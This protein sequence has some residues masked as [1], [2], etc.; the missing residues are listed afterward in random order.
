MS[1]ID[2]LSPLGNRKLVELPR[3]LGRNISWFVCWGVHSL[4]GDVG[5]VFFFISFILGLILGSVANVIAYRVPRGESVILPGSHCTVCQQ[6][7]SPWELVPILS[8]LFLHGRCSKCEA[9]VSVRYPV[10]ELSTALLFSLTYLHVS[11][12]PARLA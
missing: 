12:W 3:I 1:L 4:H 7:L 2:Y 5:N 10:L 9:P 11:T 8:W 6:F